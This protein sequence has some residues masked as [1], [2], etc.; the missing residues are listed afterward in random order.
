MEVRRHAEGLEPRVCSKPLSMIIE[1][2]RQIKV[3]FTFFYYFQNGLP[4]LGSIFGLSRQGFFDGLSWKWQEN[5]GSMLQHCLIKLPSDTLPPSTVIK[6]DKSLLM[7]CSFTYH[8]PICR[9]KSSLFTLFSVQDMCSRYALD[10]PSIILC[11]VSQ[12]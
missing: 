2:V 12:S 5:I 3:Y 7:H 8:S 4:F 6:L 9:K 11:I 10:L 1:G